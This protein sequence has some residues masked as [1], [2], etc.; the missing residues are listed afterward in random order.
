MKSKK[1][2]I[3][4]VLTYHDKAQGNLKQ[5]FFKTFRARTDLFSLQQIDS[6]LT[7]PS[8]TVAWISGYLQ[9]FLYDWMI[10]QLLAFID[11]K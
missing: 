10:L 11:N 9:L 5:W 1:I 4:K 7:K 3:W 2:F 8:L 6:L